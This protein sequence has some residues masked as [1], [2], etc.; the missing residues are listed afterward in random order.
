MTESGA[1]ANQGGAAGPTGDYR[2]QILA[3]GLELARNA[4][5]ARTL[6]ELQFI[7]VNDVRALLSFDRSFLVTHLGGK[8][9]LAAANN[10]PRLDHRAE[11]VSRVNALAPKLKAVT[12][13]LALTKGGRPPED[14]PPDIAD[15]LKEYQEYS[16]SLCL[17]IAPLPVYDGAAGHLVFEFFDEASPGELETLTLL[18]MTPFFSAALTEKWLLAHQPK[19]R[20]AFFGAIDPRGRG[21]GWARASRLAIL[22]ALAVLVVVGLWLPVTLRVG[23]RIE[24]VPEYEYFAFVQMDGIVDKVTAREGDRVKEDQPV[25]ELE[26]KE[27]DY[28]I[29][30]AGRTMESFKAEVEILRNQGAENPAKLAESQLTAIKSMRAGYELEFLNWQKQFLTVCAPRAGTILT[31]KLEGL[32]GKRFKAGEPFCRIAPE[33]PLEADIFVRE[34]DVPYTSPGQFVEAFFNFHPEVA[35][36]LKVKTVSP[37]SETLERLGGVFRVRATF[38]SP[39]RELKPGMLGIA[40]IHASSASLWFVLTRRIRAKIGEFLLAL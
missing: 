15:A 4:V 35:Y 13:A 9:V 30:E 27:I 8:S 38:D 14:I 32:T 36:T 16:D 19:V 25:A 17:L 21:I 34:S 12:R 18:N 6:D 10:Q 5:K 37:I 39:P 11:F 7:L 26:S 28:K 2:K 3:V 23:G 20:N 40:H 1:Q 31:K 33:D 22:G 29:R 24:V